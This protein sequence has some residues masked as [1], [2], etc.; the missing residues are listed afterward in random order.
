MYCSPRDPDRT[1]QLL[2][3]LDL[4]VV[5]LSLS[6]VRSLSQAGST[7]GAPLLS[8]AHR[9]CPSPPPRRPA[10]QLTSPPPGRRNSGH[11]A[12]SPWRWRLPPGSE[13]AAP[14]R[15]P[16]DSSRSVAS[17]CVCAR[18]LC[19]SASIPVPPLARC[20]S[21]NPHLQQLGT[22]H[23]RR[24]P[25]PAGRQHPSPPDLRRTVPPTHSSRSEFCFCSLSL[26]LSHDWKFCFPL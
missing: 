14:Y 8:T 16:P 11:L 26:S 22:R 13:P 3:D 12:L 20:D 21:P 2:P 1:S 6:L 19:F 5:L 4:E 10:T 17:V 18:A 24:H 15:P 25:S 7:A 9:C 23:R